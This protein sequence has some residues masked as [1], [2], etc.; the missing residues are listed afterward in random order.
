MGIL[1]FF[2]MFGG[3]A[4]ITAA[5]VDYIT[6]LIL[7][8]EKFLRQFWKSHTGPCRS[9]WVFCH[10]WAYSAAHAVKTATAADYVTSLILEL[11]KF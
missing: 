3:L 10:F 6:S 5:A 4:V 1:P 7:E 8:L 2:G 9:G 11:E